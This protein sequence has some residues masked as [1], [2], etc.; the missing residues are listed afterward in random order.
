MAYRVARRS[1]LTVIPQFAQGV[2]FTMGKFSGIM[3]PGLNF[4]IPIYHTFG[5]VDMRVLTLDIPQQMLISKAD[6]VTYHCDAVVQYKVT[7]PSKTVINIG[8][9]RSTLTERAMS[10]IRMTLASMSIDTVLE[11]RETVYESMRSSLQSIAADWGVE[12]QSL[13]LKEISFDENMRRTMAQLAESKRNAESKIIS[14]KADVETAHLYAEA[15][16]IYSEN[17]VTLR[18]REFELYRS[19]SKNPAS[20]V[21]VIPANIANFPNAVNVVASATAAA[22]VEKKTAAA[23]ECCD[24]DVR[25]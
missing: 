3:T 17:P 23:V 15:A 8:D 9:L 25:V 21:I 1:F 14:A 4:Y 18:L 20:T 11:A 12:I 5:K 19:I 13:Q 7:D 10:C 24:D 22:A 16:E 2:R 6:N